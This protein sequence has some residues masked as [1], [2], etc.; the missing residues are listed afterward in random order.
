MVIGFWEAPEGVGYETT[1][2]QVAF[3]ILVALQA[4]MLAMMAL[5]HR[6]LDD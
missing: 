4:F 3:G 1:G 6:K 2:Y 5:N